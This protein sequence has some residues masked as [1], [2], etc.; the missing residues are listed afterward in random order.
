MTC[1][2]FSEAEIEYNRAT[3]EHADAQC[4]NEDS[5]WRLFGRERP[6]GGRY[7]LSTEVAAYYRV[8]SADGQNRAYC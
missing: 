7:T 4:W 6:I 1:P 2:C 3:F 5:G 8:H